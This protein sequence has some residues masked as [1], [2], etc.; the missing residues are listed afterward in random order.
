M[1]IYIIR[2][3]LEK[4]YLSKIK[5]AMAIDIISNIPKLNSPWKLGRHWLSWNKSHLQQKHQAAG[6]NKKKLALLKA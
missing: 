6:M 5:K 1:A 4:V 2:I 3:I